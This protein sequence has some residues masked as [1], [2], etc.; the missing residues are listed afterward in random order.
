MQ[1]LGLSFTV[2][3]L[4]L[5][6][7]LIHGGALHISETALS[8]LALAASL[9]GMWFGQLLRRR[10]QPETFRFSLFVGLL[11]LGSYLAL[12]GWLA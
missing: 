10:V 1:A 3:A 12:H 6:A 2:S 7:V 11:L 9:I 5:G 8:L 4:A